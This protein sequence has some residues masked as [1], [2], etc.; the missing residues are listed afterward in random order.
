MPDTTPWREVRATRDLDADAMQRE[1]LKME[2][3]LL[4]ERA[5]VIPIN[6]V[7]RLTPTQ[8]DGSRLESSD[9]LYLSSIAEQVAHLAAGSK[10]RPSSKTPPT[11]SWTIWRAC[12]RSSGDAGDDPAV[13]LAGRQPQKARGPTPDRVV[14]PAPLS[15]ATSASAAIRSSVLA[16]LLVPV[17]KPI[18]PENRE[19]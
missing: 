4:R 18:G 5:G 2:L 14:T 16:L 8:P 17:H 15:T 10:L 19:I 1:K 13:P 11:R 9:D 7:D 6:P 12:Q 3:I